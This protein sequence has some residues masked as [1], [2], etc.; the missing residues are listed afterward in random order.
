MILEESKDAFIWATKCVV[1]DFDV[2][3]VDSD[4]RILRLELLK[5]M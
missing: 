5:D 1:G 3:S 4:E 2:C